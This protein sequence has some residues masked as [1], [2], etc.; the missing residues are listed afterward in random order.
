MKTHLL[1]AFS[2]DLTHNLMNKILPPEPMSCEGESPK[3]MFN[4]SSSTVPVQRQTVEW[5]KTEWE[6]H[7]F[8]STVS[9]GGSNLPGQ[10]LHFSLP[11][12]G[13]CHDSSWNEIRGQ[14][15]V[16]LAANLFHG[17]F[18]FGFFNHQLFSMLRWKTVASGRIGTQI[19]KINWEIKGSS[20]SANTQQWEARKSKWKKAS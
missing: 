8:M 10:P 20:S 9:D 4:S 11:L 7:A 1:H 15:W 18:L 3:S 17:S 16:H 13:C 5:G 14:V 2:S 12:A 6:D 19:L